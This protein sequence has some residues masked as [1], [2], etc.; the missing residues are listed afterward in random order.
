MAPDRFAEEAERIARKARKLLND[1]GWD[2]T[3]EQLEQELE[4]SQTIVFDAENKW[5]IIARAVGLQNERRRETDRNLRIPTE[6]QDPAPEADEGTMT[7]VAEQEVT[8]DRDTAREFLRD[9]RIA[10]PELGIPEARELLREKYGIDV[11]YSAFYSSYWKKS[12]PRKN[13][14]A[15]KASARRGKPQTK[16]VVRHSNGSVSSAVL[17][18][19]VAVIGEPILQVF[20]LS[21]GN[22]RI[23][24]D[25]APE[26]GTV[27]QTV[28][29]ALSARKEQVV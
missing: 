8:I 2:A 13:G 1:V 6:K 29:S 5:D 21:D 24:F 7:Q 18:G 17:N 15:R 16:A 9:Q 12:E 23:Q 19:A 20:K 26:L 22:V 14:R 10:N 11:Q 4:S 25:M 28:G 27:L 3:R